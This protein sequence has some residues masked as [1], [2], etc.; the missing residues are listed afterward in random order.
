MPKDILAQQHLLPEMKLIRV[1]KGPRG[2]VD[3]FVHMTSEM[4]V[5]P[6]WIQIRAW[7]GT[8]AGRGLL[9]NALRGRGPEWIPP[10]QTLV[11]IR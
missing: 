11:D 5:C 10:R 3:F 9:I 6:R 7:P 8:A 2:G 1:R 4:E